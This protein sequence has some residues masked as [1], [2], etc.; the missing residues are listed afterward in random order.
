MAKFAQELSNTQVLA[1]QHGVPHCI[2]ARGLRQQVHF[3]WRPRLNDV[4]N[5][6]VL[7]AAFNGQYDAIVTWNI[8]DF[9]AAGKI[10]I[11]VLSPSQYCAG[12]GA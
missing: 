12:A 6:M 3:L 8:R 2:C 5:A 10:G 4:C 7:E 11:K 9:F 1:L